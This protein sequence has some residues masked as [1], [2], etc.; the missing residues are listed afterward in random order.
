MSR[1]RNRIRKADYFSDGE[2]LRWPRDKR[3]TYSGLWAMAEDSGCL[4]DDC[5]EWKMSLW[6]SPLDADITVEILEQWRDELI[7]AGKLIPYNADGKRYLFI[8]TF[9]DHEKPT[10]PQQSDYP[11]PPW[12]HIDSK[13]GKSKDGKRWARCTYA[14][15]TDA[16]PRRPGVCTDSVQTLCRPEITDSEVPCSVL[17]CSVLPCTEEGLKH[18]SDSDE[19]DVIEASGDLIPD[20]RFEEFWAVYPRHENKRKARAAWAR[21]T[22]A[23]RELAI[24]VATIM[25]ELV[26]TGQHERRY[27]PH[28]TTFIHGERWEDWREGVPAGW[29]DAAGDGK[30]AAREASLQAAMEMYRKEHPDEPL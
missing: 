7:E 11:L 18:M 2:L 15:C 13:Q 3:T 17:L 20:D 6:P 25:G 22:R 30:Q 21:V 5:F 10:N 19:P 16:I 9:H 28:P 8:R 23:N 27:V 26:S 14:V 12:V 4:E 29:G 1:L 24:G